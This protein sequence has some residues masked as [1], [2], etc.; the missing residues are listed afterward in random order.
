MASLHSSSKYEIEK[1]AV[2]SDSAEVSPEICDSH[3]SLRFPFPPQASASRLVN[4]TTVS[5]TTGG[6]QVWNGKNLRVFDTPLT[7]RLKESSHL[8]LKGASRSLWE[9]FVQQRPRLDRPKPAQLPLLHQLQ[10]VYIYIYSGNQLQ[11][12]Y[13]WPGVAKASDY[14]A[15]YGNDIRRRSS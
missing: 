5:D 10:Y 4:I 12:C 2:N 6:T 3:S 14:E 9:D 13:Y 8:E 1:N 11:I 15:N 7:P